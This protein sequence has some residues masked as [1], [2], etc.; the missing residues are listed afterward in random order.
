MATYSVT[1]D[2]ADYRV[3]EITLD[4]L[5]DQSVDDDLTGGIDT[6]Q[7]HLTNI[8]IPATWTTANITFQGSIDDS[9]YKPIKSGGSLYTVTVG[10]AGDLCHIPVSDSFSFPRYIKIGTT[11][12]QAADR[13][14][15]LVFKKL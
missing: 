3:G 9:T 8:L 4:V 10:A 6:G 7:L 1:S 11:A 5:I 14:L 13:T 2:E 12:G 15:T